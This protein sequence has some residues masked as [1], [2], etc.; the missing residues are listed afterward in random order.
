M[1]ELYRDGQSIA[2]VAARTGYGPTTVWISLVRQGVA[3]RRPGRP[4]P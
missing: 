4:Q 1:A 2:T 3:L